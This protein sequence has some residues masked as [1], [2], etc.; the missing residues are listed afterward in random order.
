MKAPGYTQI[1]NEI[2]DRLSEISP[3]E[4]KVVMTICRETFGW[5]M[6]APQPLPLSLLKS[7]TGLSRQGI[8][9]ALVN[10]M[11]LQWVKREPL[12]L[13]TGQASFAYSIDVENL[14]P[15]VNSVDQ[16]GLDQ[17]TQLTTTGQLSGPLPV[18]SVD[19]SSDR[20]IYVERK[21]KKDKEKEEE[22]SIPEEIKE[23]WELW[24]QHL[25][26]K[27]VKHTPLA[28]KLQLRKLASMGASRANDA[29]VH[30]ITNGYRGIYEPR[31]NDQQ[32]KRARELAELANRDY[33]KF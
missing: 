20:H 22:E 3:A 1:P 25:R 23:N 2:L 14:P 12:D 18:N 33:S 16:S 7:K 17:S 8:I 9:D 13:A 31:Q 5:R 10:L 28:A 6:R 15:L 30:S 32:T 4:T 27:K 11:S 19:Q 21:I 24:K 26:E 29:I